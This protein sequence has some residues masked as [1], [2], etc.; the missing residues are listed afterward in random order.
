MHCR[1]ARV[2][3]KNEIE[4]S[5]QVTCRIFRFE[6]E[7]VEQRAAIFVDICTKKIVA[8]HKPV[9]PVARLAPS[10]PSDCWAVGSHLG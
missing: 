1:V 5:L 8:F 6:L 10:K 3:G 2:G 4:F 7:K 9:A